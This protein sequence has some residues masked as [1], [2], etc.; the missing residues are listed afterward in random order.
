MSSPLFPRGSTAS[1]STPGVILRQRSAVSARSRRRC[2]LLVAVGWATAYF[3]VYLVILAHK[4]KVVQEGEGRMQEIETKGGVRIFPYRKSPPAA[5]SGSTTRTHSQR[6]PD[7][8][9][10]SRFRAANKL[11][12]QVSSSEATNEKNDSGSGSGYENRKGMSRNAYS[13]LVA[14]CD[15][16][17]PWRYRAYLY[18]VAVSIH[19]LRSYGSAADFHVYVELMHGTPHRTLLKE[20]EALLASLQATI[21]YI[22]TDPQQSFYRSQLFKFLV[23]NLTQYDHV[24][25]MDSD[26][27]PLANLDY[28]FEAMDRRVLR[29]NVAFMGK[30]E[31]ANG[32]AFVLSPRSGA[33]RLVHD[34]IVR[35][36]H[37]EWN[38][39]VG[40]GVDASTTPEF[41]YPTTKVG[42]RASWDFFGADGDQGLLYYWMKFVER[43]V[44]FVS[45]VGT[46]SHWGPKSNSTRALSGLPPPLLTS[47]SDPQL[48]PTFLGKVPSVENAIKAAGI[49][50]PP[51]IC[52]EKHK[53]CVGQ[54]RPR[55]DFFHFTGSRKPWG[56]FFNA[57]LSLVRVG[58]NC[59]QHRQPIFSRFVFMFASRSLRLACA[60]DD[61]AR[62]AGG[63]RAGDP[64]GLRGSLLVLAAPRA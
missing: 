11:S 7:A 28:L 14:G 56:A 13:F 38:E 58:F 15:P 63:F 42:D 26:V 54:R 45:T 37:S 52:F 55:R 34:L 48:L 24:F 6:S 2:S 64:A 9:A 30:R 12:A 53:F 8:G 23:L 61:S 44:S 4:M 27:L 35:K 31:P 49:D 60:R 29:C 16:D 47:D 3:A 10:A 33:L 22:P 18:G 19:A 39:S 5:R 17:D 51:G 50:I 41:K 21:H 32:G 57:L 43:D 62:F 46:A 1:S 59:S 25:Y 36:E 20:E 40:W